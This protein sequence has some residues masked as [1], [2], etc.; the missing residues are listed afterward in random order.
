MRKEVVYVT[1]VILILITYVLGFYIQYK[2]SKICDQTIILMDETIIKGTNINY[3]E[4][5]AR[6]KTCDGK[7][8]EVPVLKIKIV[9]KI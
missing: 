3:Y 4:G 9:K 1:V 6:I 5:M 7:K 8:I 2:E